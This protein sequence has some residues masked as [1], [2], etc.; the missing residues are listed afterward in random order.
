MY[1]EWYSLAFIEWLAVLVAA[2]VDECVCVCDVIAIGLCPKAVQLWLC[3]PLYSHG[4]LF[5]K[6]VMAKVTSQGSYVKHA[7]IVCCLWHLYR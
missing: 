5:L 2:S 6:V 3:G 1:I 7:D 4:A